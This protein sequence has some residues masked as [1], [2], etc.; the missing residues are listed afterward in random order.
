MENRIDIADAKKELIRIND[1]LNSEHLLIG[2]L[3]VNQYV[4]DRI[5]KDID[6]IINF[7]NANTLISELYPNLEWIKVEIND[8]EYRPS[9]KI[10]NRVNQ[11]LVINFGP[12]ILQRNSYD[13]I[14]WNLLK[15]NTQPFQYLNQKLVNILVPSCS[16][17]SF[18][19]I[20][21]YFQRKEKN[22]V[23]AKQDLV[24]FVNLTNCTLWN[25]I[26]F[27]TIVLQLN[28]FEYLEENISAD[29]HALNILKNSSLFILSKLFSKISS[30]NKIQPAVTAKF[31]SDDIFSTITKNYLD[32]IKNK[33]V[34]YSIYAFD[35][36]HFTALNLKYGLRIGNQIIGNAKSVIEQKISNY[37]ITF[38]IGDTFF[39]LSE[40]DDLGLV[41]KEVTLI[42][43]SLKD[44][45]W[46]EI[47]KN[48]WLDFSYTYALVDNG[49]PIDVCACVVKTLSDIKR[50]NVN[51]LPTNF[52]VQIK[53]PVHE[54]MD[55]L[56]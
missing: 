1:S 55:S 31:S 47:Q 29:L 43:E 42:Y 18:T 40:Q 21:S 46:G 25:P 15:S 27:Y 34:L 7:E 10:T 23:K 53:Y 8:D 33:N 24:D 9:W 45:N 22:I 56:S 19:K 54:F 52:S 49:N 26:D 30:E 11:N 17:L 44:Y 2:G 38:V 32:F 41:D 16:Y 20:I 3:A 13:F 14:D 39:V 12:K 37:N 5:S 4:K 48:I 50:L 28:A 6:L 51:F 36:K 35:I